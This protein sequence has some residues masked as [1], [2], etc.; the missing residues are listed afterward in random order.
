MRPS[1]TFIIVA[2]AVLSVARPS[3]RDADDRLVSFPVF[4]HFHHAPFIDQSSSSPDQTNDHLSHLS[5]F[6]NLDGIRSN[7]AA[8]QLP[9]SSTTAI[10]LPS[11]ILVSAFTPTPSG[12]PT[13]GSSRAGFATVTNRR[14]GPVQT[15]ATPSKP[16]SALMPTQTSGTRLKVVANVIG[17]G[18]VAAVGGWVML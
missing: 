5:H 15:S 12:S 17:A 7:L 10:K 18:F 16:I 1:S 8:R 9:A 11:S 4:R 2:L 3:P 13:V 6:T 14:P